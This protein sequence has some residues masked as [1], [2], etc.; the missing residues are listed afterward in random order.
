MFHP[1]DLV[2]SFQSCSSCHISRFEMLHL[3]FRSS[4]FSWLYRRKAPSKSS[5]GSPC[6]FN[7]SFFLSFFYYRSS[8]WKIYMMVHQGFLS[9]FICSSKFLSKLRSAKLYSKVNMVL[10]TCFVLRRSSILHL[11]FQSAILSTL[12]FKMVLYHSWQ[13]PFMFRDSHVVKNEIF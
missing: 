7:F 9:F 11:A 5:Q 12:S 3:F 13:F 10:N 8:P 1:S 6:S 4:K 2:S